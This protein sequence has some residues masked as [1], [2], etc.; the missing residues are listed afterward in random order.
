M[1]NRLLA[2]LILAC[3]CLPAL[4]GAED[5]YTVTKREM[6]TRYDSPTLT[7]RIETA[8]VNG[9]SCYLTTVWL[10]DP[11]RQIKKVISPWHQSL[12]K[13]EDLAKKVS[14]AALVINGSGYVSPRYPEIPDIYPGESADYYYTPLGSI[15]VVDGE[16]YRDLRGVPFYGLTLEEDGLHMY[17]GADNADVLEKK[18]IQTWSFYEGCPMAENG[19]DIL[20][21]DWAFANR[22]AIR[23]ILCKLTEENTY[24]ILTATSRHGL[25]LVEANQFL[26]GEF[27]TEWIYDLDGGPSTALFRR[28]QGKKTLKLIYGA[29]Q[30]IVDVMGFVE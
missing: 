14:G 17:A 21:H 23:T 13:A 25:T 22:R 7:Y 30:K 3:V 6:L 5:A 29:G 12:A 24:L 8:K 10:Q 26:L 16:V 2:L 1:K 28:L 15:T 27:D 18:P 19:V 9:T 4:A 11:A 20:D